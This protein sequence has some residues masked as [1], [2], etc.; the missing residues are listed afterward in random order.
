MFCCFYAGNS[1][2][3]KKKKREYLQVL[4]VKSW[5]NTVPTEYFVVVFHRETM[6]DT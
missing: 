3:K 6:A 4:T 5:N 2:Q 1:G